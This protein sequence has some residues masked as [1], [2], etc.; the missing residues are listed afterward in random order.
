MRQV[1]EVCAGSVI[2]CAIINKASN[3]Q[4]ELGA[5][6]VDPTKIKDELAYLKSC[7][8]FFPPDTNTSRS[9]EVVPIH[10]DVDSQ[11]ESYRNPRHR[12]MSDQLS[13]AEK[14]R[15]AVMVAMKKSYLYLI[16][17][18]TSKGSLLTQRLLLQHEEDGVQELEIF[19][20]IIKLC[21]VSDRGKAGCYNGEPT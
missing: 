14:S 21:H 19:R 11:V 8:P 3:G 12:G 7:D 15:S 9:L 20:Q 2:V 17:A 10:D 6:I 16:H 1:R 4:H 18:T 5:M 13:V